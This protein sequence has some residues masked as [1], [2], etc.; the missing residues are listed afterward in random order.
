M[1]LVSVSSTAR[2][3]YW[4][5]ESGIHE[6]AVVAIL[7]AMSPLVSA[8]LPANARPFS[9]G[10]PGGGLA[11]AQAQSS[12]AR[13]DSRFARMC[14]RARD[15]R[16]ARLGRWRFGRAEAR[17]LSRRSA[18]PSPNGEGGSQRGHSRVRSDDAIVF[19]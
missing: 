10:W 15:A 14:A 13:S 7:S 17:F 12:A 1:R 4:A 16:L 9:S 11:L 3:R 8:W 19:H 18:P 6:S 2:S 5:S